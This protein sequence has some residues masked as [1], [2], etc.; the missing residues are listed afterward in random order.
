VMIG[1]SSSLKQ[2]FDIPTLF[3]VAS[4]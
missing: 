4:S 1:K 3:D 2:D